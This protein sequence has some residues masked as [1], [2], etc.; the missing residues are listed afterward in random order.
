MRQADR[1]DFGAQRFK[2]FDGGM[3]GRFHFG[4]DA[5]D[6]IFLGNANTNAV[7]FLAAVQLDLRGGNVHGGGIQRVMSAYRLN[8]R[9]TS[10]AVRAIM[11]TVSSEEP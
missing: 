5:F 2:L 4:L 1:L 11:P 10:S 6:E 8:K 3:H 9:A 7:R